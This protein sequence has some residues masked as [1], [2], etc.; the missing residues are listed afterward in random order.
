MAL[1]F[2]LISFFFAL[3]GAYEF[4]GTYFTQDDPRIIYA[5]ALNGL[6]IAVI[7]YL[8]GK[9]LSEMV[10]IRQRHLMLEQTNLQQQIMLEAMQ[11]AAKEYEAENR[12]ATPV[13]A[14]AAPSVTPPPAPPVPQNPT[15]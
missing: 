5:A 4:F 3:W 7:P 1:F 12:D 8:V 14:P 10:A 6:A 15:N 13:A 11:E 9:S 2:L